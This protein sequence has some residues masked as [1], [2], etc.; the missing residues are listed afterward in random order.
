VD[1]DRWSVFF[2]SGSSGLLFPGIDGQIESPAILG[3]RIFGEEEGD[4]QEVTRGVA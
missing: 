3:G 4:T 1:G 2:V